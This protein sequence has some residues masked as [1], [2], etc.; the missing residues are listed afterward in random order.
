MH[1]VEVDTA[2]EKLVQELGGLPLAL[3]QAGAYIKSLRCTVSQY[4]ELYEKQR[5]RLLNQQKATRVSE[6]ESPERLAIRTTWHLN[7]DHIKFMLDGGKAVSRFL[8]ASAFLNPNEIQKDIINVGEP[9]VEDKEFN[10]YVKTSLGQH[11]VLKMLTDFSL[12]KETLSSN[13]SVHHLVQEVIQ[14]NLNQEQEVQSLT[15]AIRLVH[16]AFQSCP[17]PDELLSSKKHGRPSIISGEQSRFYNWHKLCLHSYDLVKHLKR[18][19]KSDVDREKIFQP[20]TARIVYE[21]AIHLSANSKHDE[22]KKV[23]NFANDIFNLAN[24]QQVPASSIFPH[25]IPLPELVRRHIQYSCNMPATLASKDECR[26]EV[27]MPVH[28]VTSE[29]LDE[30]RK[31]G[32]DL[33]KKGLYN[34]ALKMYSDAIDMSKENTIPLDVT[35]LSNRASAYLKLGQYDEALQDAE[36]YILQRPKCWKGYARKA[37]ALVQI[38]CLQDAH[39]AASLTYY[40]KRNIFHD[41]EPFKRTFGSSLEKRLIVCSDISNF[42]KAL[43]YVKSLNFK[44]NQSPND[45]EDLPIIILEKNDYLVSFDTID[46]HLFGSG[47]KANAL[48]IGDCILAGSEG[49]CSVTFDDGLHVAFIRVFIAYNVSFHSRRT[50]C[51]FSHG[52]IVKLSH[53]SVESSLKHGT[54]FCCFGDLR[55]D[56]CKFH[57]CTMG[58]LLVVGNAEIQNSEF[59]GNAVALEAREGGGLVVKNCKM[60]GN[61]QGLLIGP[62][63][64]ECVIENCELYDNKRGG[65]YVRD[66]VSDVVIKDN[67]IC[68]ND[69][70]GVTVCNA[71]NVS[72][73][74][75]EILSN[76]DWG[77]YIVGYSQAHVKKNKIE[78]NQSGGIGLV[79]TSLA[80]KSVIECNH[81]SFNS[82]PG[83]YER[84]EG[85][86]TKRRENELQ[87]NKEERNQSTAQ[88]EARLCYYCKNPEMNLRKCTKCYTAQYCGKHCQKKDWK[89]HKE[90]C[91]RLLSDGSIVLNY[92]KRPIM[93]S[94]LH[95]NEQIP[96]S[97]APGL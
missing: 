72:I 64:R 78:N 68:D 92:V 57:D 41:F 89:S 83:I 81:I 66:C 9:P 94:H 19:I 39:V 5:L 46:S 22:A 32:N 51:H 93:T 52:S 38:N 14:N 37:L 85:I 75:N 28:S 20:E 6:Y 77:V 24:R 26:D 17:S 33:F 67:R 86:S 8:N 82:G 12:F 16:Y 71:S 63:A 88:S 90:V 74:R 36:E 42:S 21:C 79:T 62:Y 54:S 87:D 84:E 29:Q 3:E 56:F 4:L 40:Y 73:L 23:A 30:M 15:D 59:F 34:D 18:V 58:G 45:S 69:E 91:D 25:I 35:L 2:A 70:P 1:N 61:D 65:I 48:P 47:G 53:C 11:Q 60:Y 43:W 10:E 13:L 31:K 80:G 95:R 97:R 55:A 27:G 7:F 50:N 96:E 44:R 49:D 76:S